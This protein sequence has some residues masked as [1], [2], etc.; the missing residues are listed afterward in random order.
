M[1]AI[2]KEKEM[3]RTEILEIKLEA[4]KAIG[5]IDEQLKAILKD[6]VV[7]LMKFVPFE[8]PNGTVIIVNKSRR[9]RHHSRAMAEIDK[10]LSPLFKQ[11]KA[12]MIQHSILE[13]Q[14]LIRVPVKSGGIDDE[15]L[16]FLFGGRDYSGTLI[17]R[18]H[19]FL[20]YLVRVPLEGGKK[21]P[22]SKKIFTD[23][24]LIE[25]IKKIPESIKVRR[26][27]I[28]QYLVLLMR[29]EEIMERFLVPS[30]D[31]NFEL[32]VGIL[33]DQEFIPENME[34]MN[35]LLLEREA[36]VGKLKIAEDS[37]IRSFRP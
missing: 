32:L 34:R 22:R 37:Y 21:C 9:E 23:E 26:S 15:L 20:E 6:Y 18:M 27:L 3:F 4:R 7:A 25:R 24:E 12:V 33:S 17:R 16:N 10:A 5:R 35:K 13:S 30:D 14:Y 28:D 31:I 29:D 36:L 1:I 8:T 11:Y 2:Y 19:V